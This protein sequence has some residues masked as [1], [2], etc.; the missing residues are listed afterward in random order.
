MDDHSHTESW[1]HLVILRCGQEPR[2]IPTLAMLG[3][4]ADLQARC[5]CVCMCAHMCVPNGRETGR[6]NREG[7]DYA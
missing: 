4:A 6:E 2:G 3:G 7:E 5:V 1:F